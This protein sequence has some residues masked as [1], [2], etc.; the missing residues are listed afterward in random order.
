MN[1]NNIKKAVYSLYL[2]NLYGI[3]LKYTPKPSDK[4]KLRYTY[5]K[6]LLKSLNIKVRVKNPSEIPEGSQYLLICNHR[7][8][9]DPPILELALGNTD[10]FG[11]W[12]SKKELYNSFFFGMFVRNAGCIL[13]D[14]EKSQMG[15]FFADIKK[16]VAEGSSIF[17]FPEGTRNQTKSRLGTFKD[18][19]RIIAMKNRIPILPINI[20]T[21]ADI[22][23][24]E[25][26]IDSSIEREI[27]VNFGEVLPY[28]SRDNLE[29][30]YKEIFDI[31]E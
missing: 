4:K 31:V 6:K 25:A 26:L 15:G 3:K 23:M 12:V 2:T 30:K 24:K 29:E 18:G 21:N 28:K 7:S 9:I 8:V 16:G 17:I 11:L 22:I 19:S 27:I 5:S 14:R 1:F 10:I 13:L 20:E